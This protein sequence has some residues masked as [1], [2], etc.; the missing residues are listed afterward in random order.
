MLRPDP[1]EER[2]L[3]I[4]LIL[5][6]A[7]ALS[8]GL[9]GAYGL[10]TDHWTLEIVAFCGAMPMLFGFLVQLAMHHWQFLKLGRPHPEPRT[11]AD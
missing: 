9:N 1:R 2:Q 7:L 4:S 5:L 10:A 8:F 6:G 3:K 11:L